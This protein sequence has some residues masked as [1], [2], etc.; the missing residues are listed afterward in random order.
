MGRESAPPDWGVI[1]GPGGAGWGRGS[2]GAGFA[3]RLYGTGGRAHAAIADAGENPVGEAAGL[4]EL[5]MRGAAAGGHG[6][7]VGR[8]VVRGVGGE[9]PGRFGPAEQ[10]DEQGEDQGRY[11]G[12]ETGAR[13]LG[14]GPEGGAEAGG[15]LGGGRNRH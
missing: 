12:A 10:A 2:G 5:G 14:A 6:D 4:D 1:S 9:E 11:P 13:V 8:V 15:G 7:G 3:A